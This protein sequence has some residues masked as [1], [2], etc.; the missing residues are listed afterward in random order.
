MHMRTWGIWALVVAALCALAALSW[1]WAV[2]SQSRV[3]PEF[4][5][6]FVDLNRR[7]DDPATAVAYAPQPT[8]LPVARN[9]GAL[10]L[11]D[12]R[13]SASRIADKA[14]SVLPDQHAIRPGA[15]PRPTH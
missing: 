12:A 4:T 15:G 3:D 13:R 6:A 2:G 11:L 5:Q 9:S 10:S 1:W 8:I 7:L 14:P